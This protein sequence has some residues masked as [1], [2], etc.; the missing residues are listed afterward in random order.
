MQTNKALYDSGVYTN[1]QGLQSL[2]HEYNT[3]SSGVR[4]EVAQ[5]FESL[6]VQMLLKSVRDAN[7]VNS[8]NL[9]EGEQADFYGDLLD[10]QM[11]LVISKSGLG[12]SK[13]IESYLERN[14]AN[15]AKTVPIPAA[16]ATELRRDI[17]PAPII[18]AAVAS[19][20][21]VGQVAATASGFATAA[22]FVKG[23]WGSACE[24]A[25]RIGADPKILLAQA[26]LETNW[27][28]KIIP[29]SD[30]QSSNNLFNIKATDAWNKESASFHSLEERDGVL[31]KE[32]ARF[33]SYDSP[34][35]SFV[36]YTRFLQ[37]NGRYRDALK[38]AGDPGKF[39]HSLQDASYATD[40][41]YSDK[42]M[43]IYDSKKF[44]QLFVDNHLV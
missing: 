4:K 17:R 6:M 19:A 1:V 29:Q 27:G 32:S 39:I 30:G 28:K 40:S 3:N 11:A 13:S 10:K 20:N 22:D 23:L 26:A 24:A 12:L 34:H 2:R 43:A 44:Q 37:E 9:T 41:H 21:A 18:K 8:S 35:D 25:Q 42:V 15:A 36:D 31:V 7:K 38:N 16:G 33:R 5:Q 14:D